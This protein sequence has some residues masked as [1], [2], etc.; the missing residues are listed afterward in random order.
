MPAGGGVA[1]QPVCAYLVGRRR[2]VLIDPGDPTGPALDR[3]LELA[4]AR[5]GAIDAI[6]LTHVDPDHAAGAEAIA[7]RLGVPVFAGPGAG[8]AV[9]YAVRELADGDAVPAGDVALRRR[10]TPQARARIMSPSSPTTAAIAVVGDL[11]GVRGARSIPGP[12]DESAWTASRE[13]V[14]AIVPPDR[15]LTG[16]PRLTEPV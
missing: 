3:A 16:H 2:F 9:P 1:G 7:E 5:G 14:A 11:D 4:A 6:A 8:R 13:R 12:P 15:W 10:A